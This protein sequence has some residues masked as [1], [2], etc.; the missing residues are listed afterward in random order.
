[1]KYI[2]NDKAYRRIKLICDHVLKREKKKFESVSVTM[3]LKSLCGIIAG[4]DF[5]SGC[6]NVSIDLNC[7]WKND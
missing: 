1:V 3:K 6:M 5:L 4:G 7:L 2:H